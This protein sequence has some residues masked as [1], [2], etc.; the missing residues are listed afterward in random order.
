ME[1][2]VNKKNDL[3]CI[4]GRFFISRKFGFDFL[5]IGDY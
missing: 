5:D 2:E 1:Y 3:R 4:L